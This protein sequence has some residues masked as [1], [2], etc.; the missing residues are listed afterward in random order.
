MRRGC[1]E[2]RF[3]PTDDLSFLVVNRRGGFIGWGG[4][5]IVDDPF[6]FEEAADSEAVAHFR[7][8]VEEDLVWAHFGDGEQV[9]RKGFC[10]RGDFVSRLDVEDDEVSL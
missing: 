8:G 1:R 3:G 5:T 9:I 6:L 2:V 4:R 7:V 10:R